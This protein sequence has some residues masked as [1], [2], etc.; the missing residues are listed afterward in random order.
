MQE[1][2]ALALDRR[3]E[4]RP[5]VQLGFGRPPVKGGTP[6][7]AKFPDVDNVCT[8]RPPRVR[9]LLGPAGT[10]QPYVKIVDVGIR[11]GDGER[12]NTVMPT[13]CHDKLCCSV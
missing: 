11:H 8:L 6:V 13:R 2:D 5:A 1:V 9:Y 7:L 3:D 10:A 12:C 4:L